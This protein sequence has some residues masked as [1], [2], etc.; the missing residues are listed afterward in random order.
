MTEQSATMLRIQQGGAI[1]APRPMGNGQHSAFGYRRLRKLAGPVIQGDQRGRTLGFPTANIALGD[2]DK[3]LRQG[4]YAVWVELEGYLLP[5][6]A[7]Y[8]KPMFNNGVPPLETHIFDFS[9]DIYGRQIGVYLVSF[10]R[11]PKVFT[12]L[13]ELITAMNEDAGKAREILAM[14]RGAHAIAIA[15]S[16]QIDEQLSTRMETP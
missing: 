16:A 2:N 3:S 8:G 14:E 1:G 7:A 6:V 15:D 11:E 9:A 12:S 4:V 10:L 5:G 13:D